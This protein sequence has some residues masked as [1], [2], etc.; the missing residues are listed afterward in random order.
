MHSQGWGPLYR[1]LPQ[2]VSSLLEG[3]VIALLPVASK[4]ISSRS[5]SWVPNLY[6]LSP[7]GLLCPGVSQAP[8]TPCAQ[9]GTLPFTLFSLETVPLSVVLS[10]QAKNPDLLLILSSSSSTISN[11]P[12]RLTDF[13]FL[14]SFWFKCFLQ[15]NY[16]Y[17]WSGL[18]FS[19]SSLW[20]ILKW[21]CYLLSSPLP[22][23]FQCFCHSDLSKI[24]IYLCHHV[25]SCLK[26]YNGSPQS[27]G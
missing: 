11:V 8:Q 12:A 4:S 26:S 7:L 2:S 27:M 17:L 25:I 19:S 15:P 5:L 13:Y 20:W 1:T 23:Y 16:K 3:T 6:V 14:K 10:A 24:Q 22:I 21:L 9:N 18:H